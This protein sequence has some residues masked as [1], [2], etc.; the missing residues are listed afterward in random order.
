M[1]KTGVTKWF[2]VV[3]LAGGC[4]LAEAEHAKAPAPPARSAEQ[5]P[6]PKPTDPKPKPA[7]PGMSAVAPRTLPNGRPANG[8]CTGRCVSPK[9]Q[10]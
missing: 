7:T 3:A 6:A 8:N 2:A 9:E 5:K 10:P 1:T 4:E